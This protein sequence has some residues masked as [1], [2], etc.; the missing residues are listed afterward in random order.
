MLP[1]IKNCRKCG[2]FG[3]LDEGISFDTKNEGQKILLRLL[4]WLRLENS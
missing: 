2:A 4:C 3:I 1:K